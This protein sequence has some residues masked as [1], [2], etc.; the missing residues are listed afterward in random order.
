MSTESDRAGRA[1]AAAEG[2]STGA[3]AP[4]ELALLVDDVL[5]ELIELR[6][7]YEELDHVLRSTEAARG[8]AVA[9]ERVGLPPARMRHAADPGAELGAARS[10]ARAAVHS[11]ASRRRIE[12]YLRDELGLRESTKVLDELFG[13]EAPVRKRSRWRRRRKK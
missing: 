11:G 4:A 9:S 10:I 1:E 2:S 13:G 12:A 3:H 8:T 7:R 6:R 5:R